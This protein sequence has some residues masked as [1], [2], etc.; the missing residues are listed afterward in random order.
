MSETAPSRACRAVS[1]KSSMRLGNGVAQ[2]SRRKTDPFVF[3]S[4]QGIHNYTLPGWATK[5]VMDKLEKLAELALLS[6]FG[7]YKTAEKSRLQGGN[8][9]LSGRRRR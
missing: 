6:L 1:D 8:A 5:D 9:Q 3:C 7:L 4:L 2:T